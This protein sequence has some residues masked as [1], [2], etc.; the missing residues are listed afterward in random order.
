MMV[1]GFFSANV[2][3]TFKEYAL[4]KFRMLIFP[5][6]TFGIIFVISWHFATGGGIC[7]TFVK[8]Y[9]FLKSAFVCSLLY[10]IVARSRYIVVMLCTT[11]LVSQFISFY[12][13]N[14]MYPQFL[15]GVL[16]FKYK[17]WVVANSQY[18]WL[19][20][21]VLF[22][23]MLRH[24]D[25]AMV[26]S[27]NIPVYKYILSGDYTGLTTSISNFY[28]KVIMGA[29]GA[30]ST[31]TIFISASKSIPS[32]RFGLLLGECGRL[33]LGIYL[34]QAIVLEHWMMR[35][36]NLSWMTNI[37]FNYVV[38]PILS[39]FVLVTCVILTK[40]VMK[41]KWLFFM[42]LGGAYPISIDKS[43]YL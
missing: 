20:F 1:S 29:L 38:T 40:I 24:W 12:A 19:I 41:N 18:Y 22:I 23:L 28:Y 32:S 5:S 31:I 34:F 6:L 36:I 15:V 25:S 42:L 43:K 21:I 14:W 39:I 27:S 37:M 4:K 16:L 8:C 17:D 33:T 3:L 2:T 10:F 30:I 7:V 9:W 26:E 13:V 11:L 35:T